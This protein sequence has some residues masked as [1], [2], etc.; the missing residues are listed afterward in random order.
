MTNDDVS[1]GGLYVVCDAEPRACVGL[2]PAG[3]ST[4]CGLPAGLRLWLAGRG[5]GLAVSSTCD[6]HRAL[7]CIYLI[8]PRVKNVEEIQSYNKIRA[9]LTQS[10]R[11]THYNVSMT[12]WGANVLFTPTKSRLSKVI[13]HAHIFLWQ[14]RGRLVPIT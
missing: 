10:I 11:P 5:R 6:F 1:C 7:W 8:I 2:T 9:H 4:C 12:G 3:A 13:N 14:C